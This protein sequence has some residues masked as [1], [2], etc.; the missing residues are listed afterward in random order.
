MIKKNT[1]RRLLPLQ[2]LPTLALSSFPLCADFSSA[3]KSHF[4]TS[5]KTSFKLVSTSGSASVTLSSTHLAVS[6]LYMEDKTVLINSKKL[7]K[8]IVKQADRSPFTATYS[9]H[10]K[11]RSLVSCLSCSAPRSAVTAIQIHSEASKN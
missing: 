11:H 5:F 2:L 9:L 3:D 8:I 6:N 4:T 1:R 7:T 10:F